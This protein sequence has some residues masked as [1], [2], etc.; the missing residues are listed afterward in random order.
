[1]LFKKNHKKI[2]ISSIKKKVFLFYPRK[3]NEYHNMWAQYNIYRAFDGKHVKKIH[4]YSAIFNERFLNE[5]AKSIATIF[6]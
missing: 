6:F 2:C 1:M 3:L 5:S 4:V